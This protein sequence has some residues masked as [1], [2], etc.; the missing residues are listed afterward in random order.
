MNKEQTFQWI[1]TVIRSCKSLKQ[2]NNCNELINSFNVSYDD[3]TLVQLLREEKKIQLNR[4]WMENCP[5][6]KKIK[7][8]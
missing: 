2:T 1:V 6:L 8:I 7:F 3:R 4:V 5:D